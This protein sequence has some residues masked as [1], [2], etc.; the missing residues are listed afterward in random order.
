MAGIGGAAAAAAD[1]H[2]STLDELLE[3]SRCFCV[4]TES[5]PPA[6]WST[7]ATERVG[8]SELDE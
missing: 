8:E 7:S 6:Q 4:T 5:A 3:A 2:A 1:S